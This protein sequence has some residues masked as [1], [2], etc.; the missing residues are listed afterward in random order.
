MIIQSLD[1]DIN[2]NP[3]AA[4]RTCL[5]ACFFLLS[6][7][8]VTDVKNFF[9]FKSLKVNIFAECEQLI[10]YYVAKFIHFNVF[11]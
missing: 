7:N 4:G 1:A 10:K 9:F 3:A 5:S 2:S 8:S 11:S 6:L